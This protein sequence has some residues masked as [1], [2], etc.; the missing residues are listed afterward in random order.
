MDN[1]DEV[2]SLAAQKEQTLTVNAVVPVLSKIDGNN[3]G[4]N[5]IKI[6][7]IIRSDC[8]KIY[9]FLGP[10]SIELDIFKQSQ[11]T[12]V[13]YKCQYCTFFTMQ[14]D[15]MDNHMEQPPDE[16]VKAQSEKQMKQ[17]V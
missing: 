4:L 10:K 9:I 15:L 17:Q 16:C 6:V 2:V 13:F 12:L 5:E 3:S 11:E 14:S 8:F 1:D 7:L